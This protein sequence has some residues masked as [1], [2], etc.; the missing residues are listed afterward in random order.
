MAGRYRSQPLIM[1]QQWRA[2]LERQGAEVRGNRIVRFGVTRTGKDLLTKENICDLSYMGLIS[3]GGEEARPFL[4]GQFTSD[5]RQVTSSHSQLSAYC[6]PKGRMLANF[7]VFMRNERYYLR[8]PGELLEPT[9]NRLRMFVL[10]AKVV[11]ADA[12]DSL[13]RIG[14]SG[15]Q[16][17]A[18]LRALLGGVPAAIDDCDPS[19]D[20]TVIRIPGPAARFEIY[21]ELEDIKDIWSQ[22]TQHATPVPTAHWSLL[23]IIAGIPNVLPETIGAFVPQMANMEL[24]GAVSLKKGCYPGQE[25]VARMH[26]L[27]KLKRRMYRGHVDLDVPP[28]PGEA[29]Y[30]SGK[31]TQ[32]SGTIVDAQPHPGG[33]VEVLT[34]IQT[35]DARS[36]DLR[37]GSLDGSPLRLGTLPYKVIESD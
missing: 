35:S 34:V 23:D 12:S 6:N 28:Q 25:V 22:L 8:L 30:T 27:G 29:V 10:R 26:Y 3:A 1:I 33:G 32:P 21:G 37:L 7:R 19:G 36:G 15:L 31:N 24:V 9:L 5:V 16:A 18:H 17:E 2:F 13:L 4:Q 20:L 11:L 14:Y